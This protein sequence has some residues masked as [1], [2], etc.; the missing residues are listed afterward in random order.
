MKKK[1]IHTSQI[2]LKH[3]KLGKGISDSTHIFFVVTEVTLP[4]GILSLFIVANYI[5][6]M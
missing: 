3:W 1:S 6:P 4:P 2:N 5:C